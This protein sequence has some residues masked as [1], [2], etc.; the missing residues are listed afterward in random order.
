MVSFIIIAA[1]G[2]LVLIVLL[3]PH[4]K[5]WFREKH[6]VGGEKVP[7]FNCTLVGKGNDA[8]GLSADDTYDCVEV[9]KTDERSE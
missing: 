9:G 4:I 5:T 3:A 7:Q 8:T 6:N 1:L 2:I